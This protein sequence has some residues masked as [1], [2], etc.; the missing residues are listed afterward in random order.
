[1]IWLSGL[2]EALGRVLAALGP[3]LLGR[4]AGKDAARLEAAE[5]ESEAR[6]KADAV[7]DRVAR[8]NRADIDRGLREFTRE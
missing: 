8:A 2:F 5:A 4:D 1:M 6:R 7:D 3:W